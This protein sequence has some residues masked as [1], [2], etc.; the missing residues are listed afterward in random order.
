M[1]YVLSLLFL[2]GMP[3]AFLPAAV[4]QS[5][6]AEPAPG[7]GAVAAAGL[8]DAANLVAWCVVPFDAKKRGPE[9]RAAMLAGLGLKRLAYDWRPEHV[10]TFDEEVEAMRRHGIEMTAWW[11]P[12]SL[13]ATAQEILAV[14]RRHKITPQLWVMGGGGPVKN[15]AEQKAQVLREAANL[16]PVA[17]AAAEAGCLIALYNHGGWFGEPENQVEIIEQLR[18]EGIT[19]AGIV[20]NFHHGHD[21]V[22]RFREMLDR[23]KPHLLAV[24]LNGMD[25]EGDRTG[26]KILHLGEGEDELEMMRILLDS[27]W[28]GPVGVIDH[29]PETDTLETLQKNLSGL[30]WLRKEL[31]VAGSGGARPFD[32]GANALVPGKF[33][34]ALDAKIRPVVKPAHPSWRGLPLTVELWAKLRNSR[35]FNILLASEPKESATHWEL[36][37]HAGSGDLSL[38]LPGRGGDFRTGINLCDD[39]WHFLSAVIEKTRV[40]LYVDG[41]LVREAALTPVA[42]SPREGG[43]GI[44]T[45]V[46]GGIGCDG[47]I[48]EVHL[49]SGARPPSALPAAA[50]KRED[51]TT[52]LWRFD[53][54]ADLGW[55]DFRPRRAPLHPPD[56]PLHRHPVNRDRV[57]DFYAKQA[58]HAMG[59]NSAP[60]L[61]E[62]FPGLDGAGTGHWGNQNE[63]TWKGD[64]WA[65][66]DT[67]PV[68]A[69]V[70]RGWG[71]TVARA[72]CVKVPGPSSIHACFDPDTL[73][74]AAAWQGGFL[75]FG[76]FRHGFLEGLQPAGER[77][78]LPA[79]PPAKG[80]FAYHG[81]HRNGERVVFHYTRNGVPW[82][83][84][85]SEAEGKFVCRKIRADD[86]EANTLTSPG[87]ASWP[88]VLETRGLRGSGEYF[89]VDTVTLPEST[90]WKSVFHFGDHDF[91]PDGTAAVCTI[92]GEVWLAGGL[93]ET[94]EKVTWKRFAAGLHQ[95]LGLKISGGIIHVLGR[96]Q[97]TRLHDLN[98]DGEA[99]RYECFSNAYQ[100]SPAGHDFTTGLQ[101][102]G[103]GRFYFASSRQGICR[104]SADGRKLE[105][106]ATAF[107]NPNGLGVGPDGEV[108]A[109]VQEGEWTP[110]SMLTSV[111]TGGHY[112]YG[113]PPPRGVPLELPL[114]YLPRAL[115][116]SCGG[117]AFVEGDRWGFP[118]TTPVHLS[119][120]TGTAFAVVRDLRT[121]GQAGVMLLPGDFASGAHRGR[122][123]PMDGQLWVTGTAGWGTY[124]P[125]SGC[126]QRLRYTGRP[127]R[128]AEGFEARD[129]GV[130]ITFS[131][132]L[133]DGA[134]KA[135]DWFA[136]AWN[137]RYGPAYGSDEY[138]VREPG[139]PGHDV[140]SIKSVQV[141]DGGRKLFLE[142]PQLL[143]ANTLH[144]YGRQ[145]GLL[146]ADFFLTM[147]RLAPP[148]TEFPG[149]QVIAKNPP[150]MTP[151]TTVAA[152]E[153][154]PV[155][156][157]WEAGEQGR[158]LRIQATTGLQFVQQELLASAGER[159]SLVFENPDVVP[160]N[161]VLGTKGSA[162]VIFERANH[163]IA[164]ARA[165]ARHYVPDLPEVLVFTRMVEP[166]SSTTIHFNAP[167]EPGAYPY[168]CTFPGHGM[169]MR[170]VLHVK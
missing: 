34:Q 120:G 65:K 52:G 158:D 24:N 142:M 107:R 97:I 10:P 109:A 67:G 20:Y 136:Q 28:R 27:G 90:P 110:A 71:L 46:E 40:Q 19:N 21:H 72:V 101:Q 83:E 138:S 164:E 42:G 43:L 4:A 157:K 49:I 3:G 163:M 102:D 11:F 114:V 66:M 168:L 87:P 93:D 50:P 22:E 37:T 134:G 170:G 78:D 7:S 115:D 88:Q 124:T 122:F 143:P 77:M 23:M 135:S 63:E 111:K 62:S 125:A 118:A 6:A 84:Y 44:G 150:P 14:I 140:V 26:R 166:A 154:E 161:W 30:E 57:Y 82:L 79:G 152:E 35:Q 55:S 121:P 81:F 68:Q 54:A 132:P 2:Q 129:N 96:D 95:P 70:F 106:L 48:D 64:G 38:F 147:H 100:C 80:D 131:A 16:R 126:F 105:V 119:F 53:D 69:G 151:A 155:P 41:K 116:N 91:F 149:Y 8:Y 141:L 33:G 9:E 146:A 117:Q 167:A 133:P 139:T 123:H 145:Q 61:L 76:S 169:I 60:E 47:L 148:F 36:Y 85:A 29:L 45:L 108:L 58:L 31:A 128:V 104:L 32:P 51:A 12:G 74:W 18:K 13:D 39:Q 17:L 160:H 159:L 56:R 99:D 92:E 73:T 75:K 1:K 137:Y 98:G 94:L 103:D 5:A 25:P 127:M 162:Q 153:P 165:L 130:L 59:R 89:A 113:G 15:K 112:G 86:P 156:V 144:L